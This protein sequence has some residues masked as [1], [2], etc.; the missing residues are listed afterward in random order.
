MNRNE[1]THH[2][3]PIVGVVDIVAVERQARAMQAQMM[4]AMFRAAW[5]WVAARM[6][7]APE[8]QTA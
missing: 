5:V 8:G 3:Q 2:A 4:A 1:K 7:R 6:R